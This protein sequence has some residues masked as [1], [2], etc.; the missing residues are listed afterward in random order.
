M[1]IN[2]SKYQ[3]TNVLKC[4]LSHNIN[5]RQHSSITY[6]SY[7]PGNEHCHKALLIRISC[8]HNALIKALI[9]YTHLLVDKDIEA[10][11]MYFTGQTNIDRL[12]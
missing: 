1:F 2:A 9:N 3:S 10:D 8:S 4:I 12:F 6:I 7:N 11:F 5:V